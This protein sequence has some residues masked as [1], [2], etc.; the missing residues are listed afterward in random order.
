M[1]PSDLD[2][3]A[4]KV[5]E[6]LRRENAVRIDE[7]T[8]GNY[9]NRYDI[10]DAVGVCVD[11]WTKVKT[12]LLQRGVSICYKPGKGLG[13]YLGF[14]GEEVVNVVYKYKTARG[15]VKHLKETKEAIRSSS[16]EAKAWID[17]RFKDIEQELEETYA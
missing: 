17:R 5:I 14:K 13:H 2:I 8:V 7:A 12:R 16:P 4:N 3:A 15:W 6:Y 11:S 9:R 1:S 10:C